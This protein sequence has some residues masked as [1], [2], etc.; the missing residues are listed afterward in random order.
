MCEANATS[1]SLRCVQ[2]NSNCLKCIALIYKYASRSATN[3][4]SVWHMRTFSSV[5]AA[6]SLFDSSS[7]R[8]RYTGRLMLAMVCLNWLVVVEIAL[9]NELGCGMYI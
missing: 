9:I 5:I 7:P 1:V 4:L 2:L 8:Y 6:S 3:N